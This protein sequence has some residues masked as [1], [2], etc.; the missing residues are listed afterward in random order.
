[1]TYI[2]DYKFLAKLYPWRTSVAPWAEILML[3]VR[4]CMTNG[5]PFVVDLQR[6]LCAGMVE[7][8]AAMGRRARH[9]PD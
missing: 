9:R 8:L 4:G 6:L 2:G 3:Q 5:A 1:M 7:R